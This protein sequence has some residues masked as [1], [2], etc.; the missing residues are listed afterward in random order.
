[1]RAYSKTLGPVFELERVERFSSDVG[2]SLG[3]LEFL[4]DRKQVLWVY[5]LSWHI[6][7]RWAHHGLRFRVPA[8]LSEGRGRAGAEAGVCFCSGVQR[9]AVQN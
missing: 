9:L 5:A 3:G 4:A 7:D 8:L 6:R 2:T 1:M